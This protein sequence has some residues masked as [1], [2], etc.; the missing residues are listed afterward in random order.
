MIITLSPGV[1]VNLYAATGVTVGKQLHLHNVTGE[2]VHISTS[3]TG[4]SDNYDTIDG[5]QSRTNQVGDT[6]AWI[7]CPGSY[8]DINVRAL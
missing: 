1:P 2:R 3:Q 4:L 7:V 5:T 6:G 8:C